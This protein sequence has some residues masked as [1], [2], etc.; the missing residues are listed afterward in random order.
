MPGWE[1]SALAENGAGLLAGLKV[2]VKDVID[3][4]GAV[5]GGGNPEWA[6]A[7][8]PAAESAAAVTKLTAA[9]ASVVAKGHCA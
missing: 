4:A 3:V 1:P 9:G 7:H 6:A 8:E 2:V 5:T